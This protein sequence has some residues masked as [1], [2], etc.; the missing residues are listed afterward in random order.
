MPRVGLQSNKVHPQET[1]T[2]ISMHACFDVSAAD[3]QNGAPVGTQRPYHNIERRNILITRT[4][5]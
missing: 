2:D 5:T 4:S 1:H 3:L